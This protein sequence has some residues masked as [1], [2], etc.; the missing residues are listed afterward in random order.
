MKVPDGRKRCKC[1]QGGRELGA[2]CPKLKR[3]DGSWNPSHGTWYG[4]SDLPVPPR[5]KRAV[6][7]AGGFG[8]R[9]DMRE[10]F[11]AAIRLLGIPENGPD[12][13][14]A[15]LE[16]LAIIQ[17]ARAGGADLPAEADIRRRY[18]TGAAFEP[19]ATGEYLLGW[20]ERHE[21]EGDWTGTTLS[22]YR[23]IVEGRLIPHLGAVPLAKLTADHIWKMFEAVD[24]ENERIIRA[25]ASD[26]P[27]VRK[28]VRGKRTCG[29]STKRRNLATLRS[30]LA[31]AATS[32]PGRPRLLSHNVAEGIKFGR[33]RGKRK[34]ARAKALLWTAGREAKWR[35]GY[36]ERAD[37]RNRPG[38]FAE[39]KRTSERP[40]NVMIWTPDH[41]GRFLDSVTG[42]RLYALWCVIAYCGVRRGEACGLR[43]DDVEWET[44]A[45]MI[46]PTIVQ[47]GW[48]MIEQDSAKAGASEDWVRLDVLLMQA[49][50][51]WRRQQVAERL[52]W[53]PAWTDTGYVFTHEDGTPFHPA[54]VSAAF[55]R[56]AFA[57]ELPPIRLH[58]LRHGAAT[59]A[60]AAGK[61]MKEV[62]VMLRHSSESITSDIYA[63]VLPELQAEVSAAV[64]SMVPRKA[65]A[66]G[67]SETGG[68]PLA[69]R[70][71]TKTSGPVTLGVPEQ[72]S[73]VGR[74]GV[75]P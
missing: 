33:D 22:G 62:S 74:Q 28:S 23:R 70:G 63:S 38:R 29:V 53:G 45:V 3:R 49:L 4:Q 25:R 47:A 60:L 21:R 18:S 2:S 7:R 26:D 41:L 8:S 71:R 39:W 56:L 48:E 37:G 58:D 75:E 54:Q 10:W 46:G 72:V 5:E 31:D 11:T 57:E 55:T 9:E 16:I 68:L 13:H 6:L 36:L 42:D 59:L 69:S 65:A 40:S 51:E 12:G 17:Q 43:W 32:V 50:Q 66:G 27:E 61:K 34:S 52:A 73:Q 67:A 19:G 20:L 24:L 1:R 44:G 14:Q 30:A 35:R 64:V 15:R